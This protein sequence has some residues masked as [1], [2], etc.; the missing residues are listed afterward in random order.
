MNVIH[1]ILHAVGKFLG[2]G[3]RHAV[4]VAV[5]G[6]GDALLDN[7]DVITSVSHAR[8]VRVRVMMAVRVEG[9]V[10][11]CVQSKATVCVCTRA[12]VCICV[13]VCE[14]LYIYIYV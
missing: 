2:V 13:F 3:L 14:G 6:L 5:A 8:A 12:C 9:W 4:S 7:D 10:Q 1:Q 11:G